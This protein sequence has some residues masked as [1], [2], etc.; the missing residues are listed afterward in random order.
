MKITYKNV[1]QVLKSIAWSK[2]TKSSTSV[3]S[4]VVSPVSDI[5]SKT[6]YVARFKILSNPSGYETCNCFFG[7][8]A[9]DDVQ[10]I[11][12]FYGGTKSL[13]LTVGKVTEITA[14]FSVAA[15]DI[16]SNYDAK[17]GIS[18]SGAVV[19]NALNNVTYEVQYYFE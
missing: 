6:K 13:D 12:K 16:S 19:N 15:G 10:N 1:V 17:F 14:T 3:R 5:Q 8:G 11:S 9:N 18:G 4:V 2:V 7:A